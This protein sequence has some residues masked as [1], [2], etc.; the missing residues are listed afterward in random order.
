MNVWLIGATVLLAGLLPCLWV[1][2]R[3]PV[4]DGLVALQ[5]AL[6]TATLVLVLLV[7]GYHRSDYTVVPLTLSILGFAGSLLFARF[8]ARRLR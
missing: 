5:T 3:E 7:E 2:M 4:V 6:A 8:L 1:L